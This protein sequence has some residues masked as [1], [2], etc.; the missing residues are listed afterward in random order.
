MNITGGGDPPLPTSK[1]VIINNTDNGSQEKKNI[2]DKIL[3][4]PSDKGPFT[5]YLESTDKVGFNIGK[6]NNIKI[7]RDIFNLNLTDVSKI[8]N[9]GLNRVAIQFISYQAANALVNNKTLLDKGYNI[10]IPFNFVT[11]KGIARNVDCDISEEEILKYCK[12]YNNIKILNVK[13]LNRKV[14][15]NETP[16][17]EP[18]GTVLFTFQGVNLPRSVYIYGLDFLISIYVAP[19]TQCFKCLRYG[20]TSKICKGKERCLNCAGDVHPKEGDSMP[21][22]SSCFYCKGTH[23]SNFKKCPEYLRQKNIKE[24]MA[25]ENLTFFEANELCRKTYVSKNDFIYNTE[26]FPNL[27]K[28]IILI[29]KIPTTKQFTLQIGVHRRLKTVLLKDPMYM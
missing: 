29:L 1:E 16:V 17:Y 24:L 12:V 11:S 2:R 8:A 27:K 7:A 22:E 26:D 23:K 18:T 5:V 15:K 20:H 6:S 3:Y 13:R 19:V 21:C 28:K 9:K 14:I 25:F 4:L 10:F